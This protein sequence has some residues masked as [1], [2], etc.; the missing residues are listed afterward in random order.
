MSHR[1]SFATEALRR[2][3]RHRQTAW[4]FSP[5]ST[6]KPRFGAAVLRGVGLALFVSLCLPFLA[7]AEERYA[8]HDSL[9]LGYGFDPERGLQL[10]SPLA[11]RSAV[12]TTSGDPKFEFELLQ[13]ES[14]RNQTNGASLDFGI[15]AR[16]GANKLKSSFSFARSQETAQYDFTLTL[17]QSYD[18][19]DFRLREIRLKPS[20][21]QL[22]RQE[23]RFGSFTKKY[24]AYCVVGEVR[25]TYLVV[26]YRVHRLSTKLQQKLGFTFDAEGSYGMG[27]GSANL[28]WQQ[29]L[30]E[31]AEESA[32]EVSH[33]E[34]EGCGYPRGHQESERRE[35]RS[36][37]NR[38]TI[39]AAQQGAS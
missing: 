38:P 27:S 24:G 37:S 13:N 2:A 16:Y 7:H 30:K 11:A 14:G 35:H 1:A 5:S 26:H 18:F 6:R 36:R 25:Q 19:G 29:A 23:K 8:F 28:K 9:T 3:I 15:E 22:A 20:A 34:H 21:Y 12:R 31:I 4:Q 17:K 39:A 10:P 33:V 32:I